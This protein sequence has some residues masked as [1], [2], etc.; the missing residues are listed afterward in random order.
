[1]KKILLIGAGRSCNALIKYLLENAEKEDWNVRVGDMDG[2]LAQ[3]KVGEHPRVTA[4]QFN[5]LDREGR[6]KELEGCDL[7]ISMLPARFHLEVAKDCVEM[8]INVI[9][10]SYITKEMTALNDAA[11][12]KN[13]LI[14]NELGVDPGI[15]HMSAMQ[16]IHEIKAKGGKLIRFESFTGGLIAPESDNNPWGYKF[17]WNPRNVVLA[18]QGGTA[19]FLQEGQ[20]KYIPSFKLFE[21]V[22]PIEIDGLGMYEGY[23][24]RDSLSYRKVYGLEDIPTIYRGTLR[25]SGFSEAWNVFVQL[26]MTQDDFE[27]DGLE[28]MSK[29]DFV[30]SFLSYDLTKPVEEKLRD[31]LELSEEVFEKISWLGIFEDKPIGMSSGSPAQVL[32]HILEEKWALDDGDKDMIVMWHR[33]NYIINNEEK[34][35]HSTLAYIGDDQEQ[36]AMAKTV[37]LPLGIATKLVL[38]GTIDAKGVRVPVVPEIYNPIL[39]ELST[40]GIEL[41]EKE[42]PVNY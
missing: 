14:L 35:V 3:R 32:Q 9:T 6:V 30:N 34:E 4:F 24:N 2:G 21:R 7:V 31:Y 15:D 11:L 41:V 12:E 40:F 8:G 33:F 1:M 37:G 36:T 25:K 5:A 13:V 19:R 17:T 39:E 26:G 38:N 20:Y 23:A 16:I 28:N 42:V 10:P 27:I 29:R 18:G 22:K